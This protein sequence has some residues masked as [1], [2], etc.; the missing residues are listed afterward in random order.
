MLYKVMFFSNLN[1]KPI[2]MGAIK[3]FEYTSDEWDVSTIARGISHPARVKIIKH[4]KMVRSYRN[5]DFC[6]LLRMSKKS[7]KDHLDKLQDAE[8]ISVTY[9]PHCYEVSLNRKRVERLE[10]W[11]RI[12]L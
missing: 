1:G 3:T 7:V 11:L 6:E 10:H 5:I 4:L 9:F 8:L 12:E 2:T